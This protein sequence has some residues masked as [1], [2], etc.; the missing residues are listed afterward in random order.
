[1]QYTCPVVTTPNSRTEFKNYDTKLK[2]ETT[3]RITYPLPFTIPEQQLLKRIV[4]PDH[5]LNDNN[6]NEQ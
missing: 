5:G 1:M 3:V 6:S 4:K 2:S